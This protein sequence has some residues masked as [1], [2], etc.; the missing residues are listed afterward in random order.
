MYGDLVKKL[1]E[2]IE[3]PCFIKNSR[4]VYTECNATFEKMLGISKNYILGRTAF[5]IAPQSLAKIYSDA[6]K[7]LFQSSIVQVYKGAIATRAENVQVVFSKTIFL[8]SDDGVAGFI[9]IIHPTPNSNVQK[10]A[11]GANAK[12][13]LL[14]KREFEVL[15]L[16]QRGLTTK[17]ISGLLL[18]SAFTI[19]DH[20]K[21]I[22]NKLGA[23]NRMSAII[24]A[25]KLGILH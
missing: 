25:Q 22:Y 4:G 20:L 14:T 18:V 19:S 15:H 9:G 5:D 2:S 13:E 17:Q 1:I 8:N 24:A 6:D 7:E 21:S 16:C 12:G 23:N 3:S 11:M 10:N